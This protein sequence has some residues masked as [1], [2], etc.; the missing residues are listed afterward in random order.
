MGK[1]KYEITKTEYQN[2]MH[3]RKIIKNKAIDRKLRV[4]MLRYEGYKN[5]EISEIT[6]YTPNYIAKLLKQFKEMGLKEYSTS[7]NVGGNHRLISEEKEDELLSNFEQNA[8]K[9]QILSV[10]EIKKLFDEEIGK[11]T[12]TSYIYRLLHR[13]GYRKIMPR[14]KHP[15]RASDEAIEASKKLTIR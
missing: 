12:Y 1:L 8:K 15:K 3:F 4:I 13:K 9:G 11:E 7:K 10:N 14:S 5:T 6:E 2:V